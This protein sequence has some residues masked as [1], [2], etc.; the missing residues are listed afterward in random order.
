MGTGSFLGSHMVDIGSCDAKTALV[1]GL[2]ADARAV[3]VYGVKVVG[4]RGV[5][6][7]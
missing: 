3:F 5:T 4:E 7:V 6:Q 2:A 1:V